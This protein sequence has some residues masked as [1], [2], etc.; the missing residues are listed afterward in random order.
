LNPIVKSQRAFFGDFFLVIVFVDVLTRWRRAPRTDSKRLWRMLLVLL[1]LSDV[2]YLAVIAT[3]DHT[4]NH[5][6][7]F[8][9]DLSDGNVRHDFIAVA[10]LMK[11]QLSAD[12][13]TLVVYY[14]RGYAENTTDPGLFFAHLL[15][16]LGQ[17]RNRPNLFF[18][19]HWCDVRYGCAFPE[20]V[21]R[22]CMTCCYVDPVQRLEEQLASGKR[23]VVWWHDTMKEVD[24]VRLESE[25]ERLGDEHRVER[26]APPGA[27]SDWM[28]YQIAPKSSSP[29]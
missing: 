9:F 3:I 6:A 22:Q 26:L 23:A 19:C 27:P 7:R 8:D 14:P 10:R 11:E 25:L 21:D 28:V 5:R 1:A 20:V 16:H 18:P 4:R 2:Y 12:D 13:V 17:Y 29:P 24:G 15:R